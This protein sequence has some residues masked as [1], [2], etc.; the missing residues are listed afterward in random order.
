M[1]GVR[2]TVDVTVDVDVREDDE[3]DHLLALVQAIDRTFLEG[4]KIDLTLSP[5]AA[6]SMLEQPVV[7]DAHWTAYARLAGLDLVPD[8]HLRQRVISFYVN[9]LA[10]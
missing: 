4:G 8:D 7:S 2:P 5:W 10:K 9:R 3:E 6:V 1:S